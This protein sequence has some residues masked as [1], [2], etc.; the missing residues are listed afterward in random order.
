MLLNLMGKR[1]W[2]SFLL[3]APVRFRTGAIARSF[4]A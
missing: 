3:Q 1:F 4:Q 2:K